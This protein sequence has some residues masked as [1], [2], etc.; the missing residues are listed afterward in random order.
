[1]AALCTCVMAWSKVTGICLN[2]ASID[3]VNFVS[4]RA[5]S[6][7]SAVSSPCSAIARNEPTGTSR[8]S[9]SSRASRGDD[10]MMLLNSSPRST[11]EASARSEEHTSELQSLMRISYAVFCLKKKKKITR[12]QQIVMKDI[13]Q[14][15]LDTNPI[16]NSN[17][18]DA[19]KSNI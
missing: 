2:S 17:K 14:K 9:A 4:V 12:K 6:S 11:P 15:I 8:L 16:N 10:S 1:M 13:T 5:R 3:A 18:F 19:H 7:L